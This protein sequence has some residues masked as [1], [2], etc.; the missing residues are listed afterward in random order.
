M[1]E[2]DIKAMGYSTE[3][4]ESIREPMEKEARQKQMMLGGLGA[5]SPVRG[6]PGY[7]Q[8]H[9]HVHL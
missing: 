6:R 9:D 1:V 7:H 5:I 3:S 2:N 8:H 4:M